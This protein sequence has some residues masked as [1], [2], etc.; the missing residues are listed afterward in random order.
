MMIFDL[1]LIMSRTN[2]DNVVFSLGYTSF[3]QHM[4][5]TNSFTLSKA[6]F[7]FWAQT[8]ITF[9]EREKTV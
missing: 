9:N 6:W 4:Y 8:Q 2:Q 7:V 5:Y 3:D 1:F